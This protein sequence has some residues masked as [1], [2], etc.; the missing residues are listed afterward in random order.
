MANPA[1]SGG[2]SEDIFKGM[3]AAARQ[4]FIALEEETAA[5]RKFLRGQIGAKRNFPHIFHPH[6]TLW[7]FFERG[8][9]LCKKSGKNLKKMLAK[10][11]Y[12]LYNNNPRVQRPQYL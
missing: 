6:N 10:S 9:I 3:S 7:L 8:T 5:L 1:P 4:K 11:R 12:V 2:D